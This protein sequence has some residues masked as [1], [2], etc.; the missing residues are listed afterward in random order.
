MMLSPGGFNKKKAGRLTTTSILE[1]LDGAGALK[2]TVNKLI[3]ND[4]EIS[5]QSSHFIDQ[6]S[7][8][9]AYLSNDMMNIVSEESFPVDED[10][11]AISPKF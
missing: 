3:Q 10:H 11:N 9:N 1:S 8:S 4:I 5:S 2:R 7:Y 6:K